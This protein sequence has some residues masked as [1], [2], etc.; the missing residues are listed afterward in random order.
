MSFY[1][2]DAILK[3]QLIPGKYTVFSKFDPAL[4]DHQVPGKASI[5]VYSL[6]VA[7]LNIAD[8][9]STSAVLKDCFLA[10]ARV[11]KRKKFQN[12]TM[13]ISWKLLFM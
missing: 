13:W 4:A 1:K 5:S 12:D 2:Q 6:N 3:V 9:L 10:Q 8:R 7:I 11:N